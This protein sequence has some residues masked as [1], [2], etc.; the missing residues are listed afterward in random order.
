V[1]VVPT[2][3]RIDS[4]WERGPIHDYR[5]IFWPKPTAADEY[6]V[7]DADDVHAVIAWADGEGRRRECSYVLYAKAT[8]NNRPGL[9]WLAGIEPTNSGPNFSRR[10][11]LLG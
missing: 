5:V 3:P 2:D 7:L 10:Q 4:D 11:P 8:V 6:D 9:V 1:R